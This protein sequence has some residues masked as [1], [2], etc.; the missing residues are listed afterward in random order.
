MFD[1]DFMAIG[2]HADDVELGMGGTIAKM[3]KEGAKGVIVD[4][5]DASMASRGTVEGRLEEAKEAASRLG[6]IPRINLG[7]KDGY[8]TESMECL[9]PLIQVIREYRPKFLFTHSEDETH[10]DHMVC[11]QLVKSAWYKSGLK[12]LLPEFEH[13]RP[14]RIYHYMGAVHFEPTFCVDISEFWD[15]KL[16]SLQ[17]YFTQFHHENSNQIE[18]ESQVSSPEFWDALRVRNEFFGR[19]IRRKYAE[20]FYCREL[21]EVINPLDLGTQA[22]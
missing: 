18:G 7:L 10:P 9:A 14:V 5:C 11:A 1:V 13:H 20:A 19:R 22:Y 8:L 17:A 12:K 15:Q 16:H 21:A 2:A 3:M 6:G 4:L